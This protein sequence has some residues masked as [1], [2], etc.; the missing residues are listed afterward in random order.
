MHKTYLIETTYVIFTFLVTEKQQGGAY[1]ASYI[2]T[3]LRVGHSGTISPE[4]IKDNL[5]GAAEGVDFNAL[6]AMC[7]REMTKRGGDIVSIQDIT[8]D[9]RL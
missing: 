5:D 1:S 4:W 8:G 9:A 2:G 7:H 3:A 6:V